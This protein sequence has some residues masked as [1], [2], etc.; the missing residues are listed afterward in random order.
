MVVYSSFSALEAFFPLGCLRLLL[1]LRLWVKVSYVC[2]HI[3]V[4]F[5]PT[6][7]LLFISLCVLFMICFVLCVFSFVTHCFL[8]SK[9]KVD[10]YSIFLYNTNYCHLFMI[11]TRYSAEHGIEWMGTKY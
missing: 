7:C 4:D 11:S 8:E 2:D 1:V 5:M 9:L 3:L 10:P 6:V